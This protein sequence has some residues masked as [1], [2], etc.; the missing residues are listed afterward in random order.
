MEG[1]LKFI[2]SGDKYFVNGIIGTLIFCIV[3]YIIGFVAKK[4]ANRYIDHKIEKYGRDAE[5]TYGFLRSVA[6]MLINFIVIFLMLMEIKA[7]QRL[8]ATFVGASGIL[9]VILGFAAQESMSNFI[10]GFFL[11]YYKPFK[12]GDIINLPEKNLMGTVE[13]IGIR[14]TVVK[15]FT[16]SRIVVPNSVMNSEIVENRS[17][18]SKK[19]CNFLF[20]NISYTSDIEKASQIIRDLALEHEYCIDVRTK[21][22][23]EN[24]V[25]VVPVIVFALKEYAVELRAAIYTKDV[26]LGFT[27]SCDLRKQIKEKFDEEGIQIPL[28]TQTVFLEK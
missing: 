17:S 12:V 9:A 2:A 6:K 18:D 24:D 16:S 13:E 19:Y 10:G 26:G 4:V 27:L 1:F 23:K 8:G 11:S 5:T 3:V 21:K 15:T 25:P 14:H 22:E 28:P 20:I 7:L